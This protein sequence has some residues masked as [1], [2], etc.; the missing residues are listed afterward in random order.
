M[1]FHCLNKSP[2]AL[3]LILA[4]D[5]RIMMQTN[6]PVCIPSPDEQKAMKAAGYK[7]KDKRT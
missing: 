6:S 5:G 7:I 4:K 1:K 3:F 2:D